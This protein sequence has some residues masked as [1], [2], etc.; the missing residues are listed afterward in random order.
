VQA[1]T[2][3]SWACSIGDAKMIPVTHD[4]ITV[5]TPL[6]N[7]SRGTNDKVFHYESPEQPAAAR[8]P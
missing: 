7:G 5:E 2:P 8:L 1:A 3:E 4:H 6:G